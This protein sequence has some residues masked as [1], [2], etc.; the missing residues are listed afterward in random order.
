MDKREFNELL[1]DRSVNR[2]DNCQP[3]SDEDFAIIDYVYTNHPLFCHKY[4][5]LHAYGALGIQLFKT[6]YP[7]AQQFD[8]LWDK[9]VWAN[10]LWRGLRGDA[11]TAREAGL[12]DLAERL[13]QKAAVEKEIEERYLEEY[14]QLLR[15]Y[16]VEENV[17][18]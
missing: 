8:E 1:Q 13:E 18:L 6:L 16:S 10:R 17:I 14:K 7:I 12:E 2:F 9:V 3:V 4:H 11:A 5:V 15:K